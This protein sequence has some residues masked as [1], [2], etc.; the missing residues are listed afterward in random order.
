MNARCYFSIFECESIVES[1]QQGEKSKGGKSMEKETRKRTNSGSILKMRLHI[2]PMEK[3]LNGLAAR[4]NRGIKTV[5]RAESVILFLLS[6]CYD[7]DF[8]DIA[9]GIHPKTIYS[10]IPAGNPNPSAVR[11]SGPRQKQ[12]IFVPR[13]EAGD[14]LA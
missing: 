6:G 2:G 11:L 12:A 13:I 1:S 4:R 5:T 3:G 8:T 9:E 10:R 7:V 14:C